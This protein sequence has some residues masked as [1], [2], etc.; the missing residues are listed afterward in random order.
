M[1]VGV[2]VRVL[3]TGSHSGIEEYT[4]DLLGELTKN[5]PETEFKLFSSSFKIPNFNYDWADQSNVSFAISKMPSRLLFVSSKF[6]NWPKI[7]KKIGGVDVFLSPHFFSALS[8]DC[9]SISIFHDLAFLRYPEFFSIK[10]NFWHKFQINSKKRIEQS[11]HIIAVSQS[12]KNDL[13]D[14]LGVDP[15]NITVA[16]PGV[17]NSLRIAVS[18]EK[19]I[20]V[21][22]KYNLSENFILFV[23]TLEPR[24]NVVGAIKAFELV[25]SEVN[26]DNLDLVLM[27]RKGWLSDEIFESINKSIFKKNIK[28]LGFVPDEDRSTIYQ[29]SSIVLYPS[30]F[31][32]FGFPPLEAMA[33]GVPVVTSRVASIPE[34]V[35]GS[36]ILVDPYSVEEIAKGVIRLIEDKNF[37][38]N[39]IKKG[40]KQSQKFDWKITAQKIYQT[41]DL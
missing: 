9:R 37:A 29:N 3:S 14:L 26:D 4:S 38:D 31:E 2:D 32:G 17:N 12:T 7:D 13:I 40:L 18:K 24:K 28:W 23:G 1:K 10:Q 21:R 41:F 33:S 35:G 11:D 20:K 22:Q 36:A 5:N 16:Y 34:V 19:K 8:R 25:K 15:K 39:L 6:I 27:G 30:F